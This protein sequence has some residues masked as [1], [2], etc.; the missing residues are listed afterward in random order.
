LGKEDKELQYRTKA[1]PE[2]KPV[3]LSG[4]SKL[5]RDGQIFVIHA[6]ADGHVELITELLKLSSQQKQVTVVVVPLIQR[7]GDKISSNLDEDSGIAHDLELFVG[8]ELQYRTKANSELRPV[9]LADVSRL[10][11]DGQRVVIH[12]HGNARYELITDI[13]KATSQRKDVTVTLVKKLTK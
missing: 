1:K 10:L 5:L 12:T 7:E 3:P 4:V 2:W 8:T 11:S 13:I 6:S 9:P